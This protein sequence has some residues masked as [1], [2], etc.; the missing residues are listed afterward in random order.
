MVI[1]SRGLAKSGDKLKALHLH[2]QNTNGHP[3]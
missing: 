2:Y 1:K 3:T